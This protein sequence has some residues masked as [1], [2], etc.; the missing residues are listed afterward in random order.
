MEGRGQGREEGGG[1]WC[2]TEWRAGQ[3]HRKAGA[4]TS[5]AARAGQSNRGSKDRAGQGREWVDQ[6]GKHGKGG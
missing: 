4:E 1:D 3:G 2:M 6:G 5:G